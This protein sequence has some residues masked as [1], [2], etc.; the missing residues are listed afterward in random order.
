[1]FGPPL[2][3][4]Y[5]Y[6]HSGPGVRLN[7]TTYHPDMLQLIAAYASYMLGNEVKE[8]DIRLI[9][10]SNFAR[11]YVYRRVEIFL[12]GVWGTI[13]YDGSYRQ[14]FEAKVVCRQLGYNAYRK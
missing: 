14:T 6:A 9:G 13:S 4:L 12:S 3:A 1:M 7:N 11:E 5:I 10:S 8:G 2:W